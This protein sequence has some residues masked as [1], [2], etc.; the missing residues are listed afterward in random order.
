MGELGF[1]CGKIGLGCEVR[2]LVGIGGLVVEFLAAVGVADVALAFG[3][4]GVIAQAVGGK[5]GARPVD[6]RPSR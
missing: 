3:A 4:Q 6:R 2:P 5:G 1:E